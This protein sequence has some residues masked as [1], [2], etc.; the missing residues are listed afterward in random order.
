MK[1][2]FDLMN[3]KVTEAGAEYLFE[4]TFKT[5]IVDDEGTIANVIGMDNTETPG[6]GTKVQ[7]P[8]FTDQFLGRAAEPLT[9]DDIDAV[10]GATISS[11]AAL[12][13]VNEAIEAYRSAAG[14]APA[15][16]ATSA[17][18]GAA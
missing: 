17:E 7:L 6:L 12:A 1:D 2:E 10:T 9:I 18:K 15:A 8:D 16:A 3:E 4:T 5:L 13:A 14:E 11:K